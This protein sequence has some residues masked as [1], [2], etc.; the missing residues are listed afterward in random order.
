M[1]AFVS[2][3]ETNIR[4]LMRSSSD[5]FYV[6]HFIKLMCIWFISDCVDAISSITKIVL[7]LSVGNYFSD[8]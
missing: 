2:L 5:V 4:H 7:S 3:V 8:A 1:G 6:A